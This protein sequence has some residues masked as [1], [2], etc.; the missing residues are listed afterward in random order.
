LR[1]TIC[2]CL[3]R[4]ARSPSSPYCSSTPPGGSLRAPRIHGHLLGLTTK[5]CERSGLG[6]SRWKCREYACRR[7]PGAATG[8]PRRTRATLDRNSIWTCPCSCL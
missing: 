2:P 3:L 5:P 1:R 7:A 6:E 8:A 4:C